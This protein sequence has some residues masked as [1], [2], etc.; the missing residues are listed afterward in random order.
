MCVSRPLCGSE[1]AEPWFPPTGVPASAGI[2]GRVHLHS[3]TAVMAK[4]KRPVSFRTRKLSLSAPMVLPG[5]LGGRVGRRRTSS[6]NGVTASAVAPFRMSTP[7]P[8]RPGTAVTNGDRVVAGR[9][10][11][12]DR[13]RLPSGRE[14]LGPRPSDRTH[15]HGVPGTGRSGAVRVRSGGDPPDARTGQE[16]DGHGSGHG[17]PT[18]RTLIGEVSSSSPTS[19]PGARGDAALIGTCLATALSHGTVSVRTGRRA[20]PSSGGRLQC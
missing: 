8:F 15:R 7:E 13:V 10:P 9:A 5:G 6:R 12:L 3:V 11:V 17:M 2:R 20:P 16:R 1:G 18:A 14:C 19:R 4:G